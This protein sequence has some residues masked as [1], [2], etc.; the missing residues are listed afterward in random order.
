MRR[1]EPELY[2]EPIERRYVEHNIWMALKRAG[3]SEEMGREAVKLLL[4]DFE[5]SGWAVVSVSPYPGWGPSGSASRLAV[6]D[7]PRRDG[8]DD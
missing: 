2:R 6:Q 4:S 5:R 3:C 1:N 7:R 8:C